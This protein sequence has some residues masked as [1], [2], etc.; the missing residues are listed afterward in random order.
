MMVTMTDL[1]AYNVLLFILS[2]FLP[3]GESF[4]LNC[5]K[6][7]APK[8]ADLT[9]ITN[10]NLNVRQD[11]FDCCKCDYIETSKKHASPQTRRDV[12]QNTVAISATT[13]LLTLPTYPAYSTSS[14]TYAATDLKRPVD[15]DCLQ[16]LPPISLD[17]V[18]IYLCRHGQTENNRLRKVQ[19][20][21]VDPPI[22][23]N[24][25]QQATN[26]GR[27]LNR[28]KNTDKPKL[29][30]TSPLSR[31]RMTT[32]I[33]SKELSDGDASSKPPLT[34]QLDSLKEVDFG[35]FAEGQPIRL[36]Q[37]K[38]LQA[39]AAWSVG[40][41]DYRPTGGGDSGREVRVVCHLTK[42][43]TIAL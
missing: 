13:T 33:A 16:D 30:F 26:L 7:S 18:R 6:N 12:L 29:F 5:P 36:V 15:L 39:Y 22:N 41:V 34:K 43:R 21:R 31:A 35:Q 4:L 38:M 10:Q 17:C 40:N 27:A 37:E 3:Q 14:L 25:R 9:R 28:A 19:G 2:M 8:K 1:R 20:S 42:R 24:G 11:D 23:D 32:D